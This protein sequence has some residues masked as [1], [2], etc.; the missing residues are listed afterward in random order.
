[1]QTNRFDWYNF[2]VLYLE[3]VLIFLFTCINGCYTPNQCLQYSKLIYSFY[4]AI[5]HKTMMV[6]AVPGNQIAF[7]Y[8][9]YNI[10][11]CFYLISR[12]YFISYMINQTISPIV[13]NCMHYMVHIEIHLASAPC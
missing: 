3:Y 11:T 13:I 7:L 6:Q 1:M 5:L 10:P 12:Y 8:T 4:S 9:R 2:L